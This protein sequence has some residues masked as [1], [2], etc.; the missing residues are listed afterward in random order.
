MDNSNQLYEVIRSLILLGFFAKK[1]FNGN[2]LLL[3]EYQ[4][5][6]RKYEIYS[7][8]VSESQT[9]I[10]VK[11]GD[12]CIHLTIEDD[13]S[14]RRYGGSVSNDVYFHLNKYKDVDIKEIVY[15]YPLYG[16]DKINKENV[17]YRSRIMVDYS[18]SDCIYT[19]PN[20]LGVC[21]FKGKEKFIFNRPNVFDK[22]IERLESMQS[23]FND[24]FSPEIILN[25]I[26]QVYPNF[27]QI[28]VNDKIN[29]IIKSLSQEE[30]L[31]LRE[32]LNG[33]EEQQ[34]VKKL[35]LT[36]NVGDK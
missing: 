24:V 11:C 28:K 30:L 5:E 4:Y 8:W 10:F 26:E 31:T 6:D 17:I 2:Q 33:T 7:S 20:N 13:L 18:R 27:E 3:G 21:G 23:V 36:N 16:L 22:R 1:N 35:T 29:R 25:I 19:N 9:S 34:I 15:Y 12:E 14:S 32:K